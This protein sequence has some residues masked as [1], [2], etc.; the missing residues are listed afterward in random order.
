MKIKP[1]GIIAIV[2]CAGL[3]VQAAPK[4]Q[5]KQIYLEYRSPNISLEVKDTLLTVTEKKDS[6]T[7]PASSIPSS[8][9]LVV[10]KYTLTGNEVRDLVK[11]IRD[12]N[13]FYLKNSYGAPEK[14][15]NYLSSIFIELSGRSKKVV[16]RSNPS[17]EEK[18]EAFSKIEAY[19]LGLVKQ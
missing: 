19:I 11:F 2:I 13:F 1:T 9:K 3:T 12:N 10:K 7:N 15:R 17:F 16:F 18:P 8:S 6:F 5:E 14:E 4:L